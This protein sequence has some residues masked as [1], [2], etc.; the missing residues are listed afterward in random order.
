M[1]AGKAVG[2]PKPT[3]EK[4]Q[5]G[6][7]GGRYDKPFRSR[8]GQYARIKKNE[9]TMKTQNA[10]ALSVRR[11]A[12]QG[13]RFCLCSSQPQFFLRQSWYT[14]IAIHILPGTST[15]YSS[16]TVEC[17]RCRAC[18]KPARR[19]F[20]GLLPRA[21]NPPKRLKTN[22]VGT[23][24]RRVLIWTMSG[25]WQLQRWIYVIW[26]LVHK[27]TKVLYFTSNIWPAH[28]IAICL[29]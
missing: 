28:E 15:S 20:S 24:V 18:S 25:K 6:D 1:K 10:L 23:K 22:A 16:T 17:V 13:P 11:R 26:I 27:L 3:R 2:L 5:T 29:L 7:R 19:D 21:A 8:A 9:K 14:N 12:K 4:L